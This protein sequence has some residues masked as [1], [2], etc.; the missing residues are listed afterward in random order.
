MNTV[1]AINPRRIEKALES[2]LRS[3]RITLDNVAG[4]FFFDVVRNTELEEAEITELSL[5][6]IA[7]FLVEELG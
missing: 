4:E 2:F 3:Y 5:E 6:R 1:N 7:Q